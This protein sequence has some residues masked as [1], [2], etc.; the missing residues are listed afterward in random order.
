MVRRRRRLHRAVWLWIDEEA[1]ARHP[2]MERMAD[3]IQR[4]LRR[5]NLPIEVAHFH[6]DPST[7]VDDEGT[8]LSPIALDELRDGA[9]VAIL[10]DGQLLVDRL[11]HRL[12]RPQVERD[13]RLLGL[14][15]AV[16]VFDFGADRH[17]L[18]AHLDPHGIEV[19]RPDTLLAWLGGSV[20]RPPGSHRNDF[21]V[22]AAACALSPMPVDLDTALA[23]RHQLDLEVEPARIRA[24]IDEVAARGERLWWPSPQRERRLSWLTGALPPWRLDDIRRFWVAYYRAAADAEVSHGRSPHWHA[25]SACLPLVGL[26]D[27]RHAAVGSAVEALLHYRESAPSQVAQLARCAPWDGD[28]EG[29]AR[30]PWRFE[31]LD[32]VTRARL[33]LLGLGGLVHAW[34]ERLAR[35]GR[36]WA[37]IGAAVA[38]TVLGGVWLVTDPVIVPDDAPPGFVSADGPRP[39]DAVESSTRVGRRRWWY[40][41][42]E[43]PTSLGAQSLDAKAGFVARAIWGETMSVSCRSR[44]L[45]REMWLCGTTE[46]AAIPRDGWPTVSVALLM[47]S[48]GAAPARRLAIALLDSGTADRVIFD[49]SRPLRAQ[50]LDL[51]YDVSRLIR[52]V[53]RFGGQLLVFSAEPLQIEPSP[54]VTLIASSDWPALASQLGGLSPRPAKD[55]WPEADVRGPGLLLARGC[56][57]GERAIVGDVAFRCVAA[58]DHLLPRPGGLGWVSLAEYW[59]SEVEITHETHARGSGQLEHTWFDRHQPMT[60]VPW[61][62]A[63]RTCESLGGRLPLTD[64]W[65][66]ACRAPSSHTIWGWAYLTDGLVQPD[67]QTHRGWFFGLSDARPWQVGLTPPNAWGLR[68]MLGNVAEWTSDVAYRRFDSVRPRDEQRVMGGSI[69]DSAGS[70]DCSTSSRRARWLPSDHIGFRCVIDQ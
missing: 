1:A 44:S 3:G 19:G 8:A 26:W 15:P 24:L 35:P 49:Q 33:R 50:N 6:G 53:E 62:L 23:L 25:L 48:D 37:G 20:Y 11:G 9:R 69:T 12:T 54:T 27:H 10:T 65:E 40:D 60:T 67:A 4:S 47:S 22:W 43:T 30:L 5:A 32:P 38:A 13:L 16:K 58:G 56:Q 51:F 45:G 21:A 36:I 70:V 46:V 17:R 55:V 42:G 57:S 68:D 18:A 29:R 2:E 52:A 28:F 64:E 66:V 59:I 63:Q 41:F 14:W 39:V 34:R 31:D 61:G 7:L